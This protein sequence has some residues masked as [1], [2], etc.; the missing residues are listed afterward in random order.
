MIGDNIAVICDN[1]AVIDDIIGI[2]G[3]NIVDIGSKYCCKCV[4]KWLR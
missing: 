2:R 4:T 3:D 1:I